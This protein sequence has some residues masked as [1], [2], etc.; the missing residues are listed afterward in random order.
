MTN[1][2]SC[3]GN[4]VICINNLPERILNDL[5]LYTYVFPR[6]L[7]GCPEYPLGNRK[8]RER[9]SPIYQ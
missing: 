8:P 6:L 7:A 1:F 4:A 3:F 5:C 9:G 2:P